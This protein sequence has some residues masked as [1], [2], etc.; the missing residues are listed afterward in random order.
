MVRLF[1]FALLFPSFF[2]ISFFFAI[3]FFV[4]DD[5]TCIKHNNENWTR[6]RERTID[7]ELR[8]GG[9]KRDWIK[10]QVAWLSGFETKNGMK[11]SWLNKRICLKKKSA[12]NWKEIWNVKAKCLPCF[13]GLTREVE[14][15]SKEVENEG[16]MKQHVWREKK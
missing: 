8:E 7:Q 10:T 14:S 3:F 13:T 9:K 12:A 1:Y 11:S 16:K 2:I 4:L 15:E 6:A 5:D